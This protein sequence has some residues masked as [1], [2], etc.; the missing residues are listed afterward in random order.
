MKEVD[1]ENV[2]ALSIAQTS[3]EKALIN[4]V[5]CL[6]SEEEKDLRACLEDLDCEENIPAGG[7]SFEE[8][9]SGSP[10]EKTKVELKILPNN[11]KYVFL[12]Q[13]ETKPVVISTELTTEEENML[14]EVLK[15]HREAIG[16]HISDLKGISTAYCM[17][18]IMM[19]EDYRPIRQ[20]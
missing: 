11:L 18:K 20:P 17:R 6:T 9:K 16:W 8:L 1:K 15:R 10:S 4:V 14:V 13:N 5:D 7:T 19:E 2:S 12:E 3:L